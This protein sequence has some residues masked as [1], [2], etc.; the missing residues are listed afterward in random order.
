MNTTV[1]IV[2]FGGLF[3]ALTSFFIL[4][5]IK[6]TRTEH[7]VVLILTIDDCLEYSMYRICRTIA[8]NGLSAKIYAV[9]E[10]C[11]VEAMEVARIF[12]KNC[13]FFQL[14]SIFEVQELLKKL[15]SCDKMYG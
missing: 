7:T 8:T 15:Q 2:I 10:N 1:I 6:P 14:I 12:E 13:D 4:S 3:F 5:V 11:D 9:V